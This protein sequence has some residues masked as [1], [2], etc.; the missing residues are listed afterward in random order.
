MILYL[1]SGFDNDNFFNWL[2]FASGIQRKLFGLFVQ[3]FDFLLSSK[4]FDSFFSNR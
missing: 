2:G 1:S 3:G 4:I